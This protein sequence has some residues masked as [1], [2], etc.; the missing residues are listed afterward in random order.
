MRHERVKSRA[1]KRIIRKRREPCR[2]S[3]PISD[4]LLQSVDV[5]KGEAI[6]PGH[7]DGINSYTCSRVFGKVAICHG[8]SHDMGRT[9]RRCNRIPASL[10]TIYSARIYVKIEKMVG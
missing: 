2:V 9:K 1:D 3:V 4:T 6:A 8:I 7:L 10:T 5:V